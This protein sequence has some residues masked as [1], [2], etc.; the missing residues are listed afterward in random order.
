MDWISVNT[1]DDISAADIYMERSYHVFL[2]FDWESFQARRHLINVQ[3]FNII[4]GENKGSEKSFACPCGVLALRWLVDSDKRSI[5]IQVQACGEAFVH[6]ELA[7]PL[8]C[9]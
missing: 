3:V 9:Q 4:S 5:E 2:E 7:A 8:S 6:L 1:L